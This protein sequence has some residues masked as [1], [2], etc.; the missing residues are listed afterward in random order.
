MRRVPTDVVKDRSRRLTR[1][2]ESWFPYKG[3][4]GQILKVG[5]LVGRL[6]GMPF[7]C[8][9][10]FGSDSNFITHYRSIPLPILP[11]L[12]D[13]SQVWT[14]TEVSDDGRHVVGHTKSYIKVLI[15]YDPAL[16]GAEATVSQSSH[17]MT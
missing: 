1:M 10:P 6:A 13:V 8:S 12:C 16:L 7:P 4:E 14:N 17:H 5:R 9:F 3:M 11:S 15:P 2:F